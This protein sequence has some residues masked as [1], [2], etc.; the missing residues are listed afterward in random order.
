MERRNHGWA[1]YCTDK[2]FSQTDCS[3]YVMSTYCMQVNTQSYLQIFLWLQIEYSFA[4]MYISVNIQMN[5]RTDN[6]N[7]CNSLFD[8][9]IYYM[10]GGSITLYWLEYIEIVFEVPLIRLQLGFALMPQDSIPEAVAHE[11]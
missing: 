8:Y 1:A 11:S 4:H 10:Q 7:T 9:D 3:K 2:G 6:I 5:L